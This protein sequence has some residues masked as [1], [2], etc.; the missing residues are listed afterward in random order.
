M[1]TFNLQDEARS[2]VYGG[3]HVRDEENDA[4]EDLPAVVAGQRA[5]AKRGAYCRFPD[6]CTKYAQAGGLCIAHGGGR[7]CTDPLCP[8]YHTRTCKKHGGTKKCSHP[9]CTNVS[10]GKT[11]MCNT[12][13]PGRRCQVDAGRGYC[14]AHGGGRI[15]KMDHPTACTKKQYRGGY[16]Y[17]HAIKPKCQ[18]EG[19]TKMDLGKGHCK[20]HGGGYACKVTGCCWVVGGG[21]CKA[22]GGG[23]SS[24]NSSSSCH[25]TTGKRCAEPGCTKYNQGGGYCLAHG[26]GV[27]CSTDGC[28]KKQSTRH[29]LSPS[30][31]TFSAYPTTSSLHHP[32]Y[33]AASMLNPSAAISILNPDTT[34]DESGGRREALPATTRPSNTVTHLLDSCLPYMY[35]LPSLRLDGLVPPASTAEEVVRS[36]GLQHQLNPIDELVHPTTQDAAL[37]MTS[38]W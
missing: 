12:H 15:C 9:D 19:C 35:A 2:L 28:I 34:E 22:H 38:L 3:R 30:S 10:V 23:N 13:G 18:S 27:K 32:T 33:S 16:C 4:V 17:E 8:E 7:L 20:T 25:S 36:H 37:T 14:M 31:A 26:G 1:A 29:H 6:G 21:R 5:G 11:R 24:S